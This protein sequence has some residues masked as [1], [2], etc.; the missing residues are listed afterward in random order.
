MGF[1]QLAP[2]ALEHDA[3]HLK[4][5]LGVVIGRDRAQPRPQPRALVE[6]AGRSAE[7]AQRR[8]RGAVSEVGGVRDGVLRVAAEQ[9]VGG[10]T[11]EGDGDVLA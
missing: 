7:R 5:A 4:E 11:A 3:A 8:A 6:P 1:E 9:L 2:A 10:L